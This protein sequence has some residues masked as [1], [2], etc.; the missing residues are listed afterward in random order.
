MHVPTYNAWMKDPF[1]LDMTASEPLSL[2][3]EYKM[4]LKWFDDDNKCIF[5]ILAKDECIG[6]LDTHDMNDDEYRIEFIT[7]N[8]HAMVGDVN[9]F[10]NTVEDQPIQKEAEL[11][12][13]IARQDARRK[14]YASEAVH[15]IMSFGV[16]KLG[17][18]H[19][20]FVK[21]HESNMESLTFFH[22]KL[23]FVE[24]NYVAC[25]G[26]YELERISC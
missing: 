25:F 4:Q 11:D 22:N 23:E 21:V 8:L 19:R 14:G 5:I 12:I 2:E 10:M 20:Y 6:S 13:M 7:S 3:E 16:N 9:L 26:E 17:I 24:C 15:L 18:N 1:L